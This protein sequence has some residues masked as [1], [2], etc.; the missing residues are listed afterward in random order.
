MSAEVTP[1]YRRALLQI[2]GVEKLRAAFRLYWAARRLKT[3]RLRQQHPDWS[4]Q[5]IALKVVEIFRDATT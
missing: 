4:E 5:K 1:E 2:N 3:A